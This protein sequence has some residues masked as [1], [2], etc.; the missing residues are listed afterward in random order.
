MLAMFFFRADIISTFNIPYNTHFGGW[1][2]ASLICLDVIAV[3][4]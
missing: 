3:C 4:S 1:L 2:V